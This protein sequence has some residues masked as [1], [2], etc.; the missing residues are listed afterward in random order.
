MGTRGA[1]ARK[2]DTGFE[3]VYHHWDSN[4]TGLGET[5]YGLYHGHFKQDLESMLE[6]LID[7]HPAGWST[8]NGKNFELPSG[9]GGADPDSPKCYC[10]GKRSEEGWRVTAENA[11][12]SGIEYAYVFDVEHNMMGILSTYIER[13]G[14]DVKM[15]GMFGMGDPLATWKPM[16]I[17]NLE[18]EEPDWEKIGY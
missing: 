7:Q 13:D 2:D 8:I 9:F 3:G 12:G 18:H 5:L 4:P 6:V 14:V 10:H 17:I 1:I 15:I 16:A 11:A